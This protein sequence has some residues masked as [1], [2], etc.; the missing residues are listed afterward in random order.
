MSFPMSSLERLQN[1]GP[2]NIYKPHADDRQ[3]LLKFAET[4]GEAKPDPGAAGGH[5]GHIDLRNTLNGEQLRPDTIP[6]AGSGERHGH[7]DGLYR[8]R[9]LG[10]AG[11]RN[12]PF[13]I[14]E[15]EEA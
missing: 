13:F 8:S 1:P 10:A 7:R 12:F 11:T 5:G 3:R 2:P 6:L 4:A 15:S 14:Q 9:L